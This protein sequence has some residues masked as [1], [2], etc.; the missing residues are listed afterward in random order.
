[1]C[2]NG[3]VHC[4]MKTLRQIEKCERPNVNGLIYFFKEGH[5]L[6]PQADCVCVCVRVCVRVHACV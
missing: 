4:H 3:D 1:M 5:R 6:T 2:H